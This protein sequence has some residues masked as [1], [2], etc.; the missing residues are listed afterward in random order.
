M[1]PVQKP[2]ISLSLSLRTTQKALQANLIALQASDESPV[3]AERSGSGG[4]EDSQHEDFIGPNGVHIADAL[5]ARHSKGGT[6]ISAGESTWA[7][8]R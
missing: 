2:N 7:L 4:D 3:R 5:F 6:H 8:G 1:A